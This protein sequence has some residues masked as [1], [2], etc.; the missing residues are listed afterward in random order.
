MQAEQQRSTSPTVQMW[1]DGGCLGNPG[2]GG[3]G[4]HYRELFAGYRL[5][6]NNRMEVMALIA[7]LEALKRP[8]LVEATSDSRYLVDALERGWLEGWQRNGWKR[9]DKKAVLNQDLWLRLLGQL[10]K[11]RVRLHWVRGHTGEPDNERCDELTHLAVT[12]GELAIDQGYEAGVP[13]GA[14]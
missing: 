6:T 1:T 9:A 5:T 11:H 3:Y 8:C 13:A 4:E 7:G 2:P 12:D 14:T 10:E